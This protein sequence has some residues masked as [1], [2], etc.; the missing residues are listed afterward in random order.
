MNGLAQ[1]LA[2]TFELLEKS[3][4]P[5]GELPS[6]LL[7]DQARVCRAAVD[8]R[9]QRHLLIS[10]PAVRPV[11]PDR[12][13]DGV[14]Y[15]H[16]ILVDGAGSLHFLDLVC[17]KPH[18][19]DLFCLLGAEVLA[20]LNKDPDRPHHVAS[21]VINRWRELLARPPSGRLD[22]S[23][24]I[25]LFGELTCLLKLTAR[26]P[27]A[28][29]LWTG[30][31][32]SGHDFCAKDLHL[33][34]KATAGRRGWIF[35]M[36]GLD[37]LEAPPGGELYLGAFQVEESPEGRSVPDLVDALVELGA[38][39]VVLREKVA[40]VGVGPDRWEAAA[41]MKYREVAHR[42]YR[43]SPDFPRLVV[44]HL[45]DGKVPLGVTHVHYGLDLNAWPG[46]PLGADETEALFDRLV[47][48]R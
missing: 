25:G 43:V 37:Q 46:T 31:S 41:E 16:R 27:G 20:G 22:P 21:R 39:G 1:V 47:E 17:R 30:P 32:G 10:I 45:V 5:K 38:D 35:E 33:E 8:D 18:L 12:G 26:S 6:Q 9:G 3:L 7:K 13:S 48:A 42:F 23:K 34:V 29:A 4:P 36:H 2:Q 44:G 14:Q 28:V 24:L 19:N 11:I 40:R 15:E